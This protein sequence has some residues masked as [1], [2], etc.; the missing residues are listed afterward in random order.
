MRYLIH[1]DRPFPGHVQSV[2]KDDGTVGYCSTP[3]T[4]E[5]YEDEHG[6]MRVLTEAE[7]DE[8]MA[9]FESSQITEPAPES[10]K[11]FDY[12]LGVLP[13]SRWT[14][15]RGVEL[16]AMSERISG[17]LTT[18][19]AQ[20]N[21]RYWTWTDLATAKHEELAAKVAQAAERAGGTE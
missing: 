13:P 21:G 12:A 3:T 6:P 15:C 2:L 5:Q 14:T 19:H 9:A 1:R 7:L 4:L 18:W 20:L 16:F 10:A 11:D 8:L 17:L